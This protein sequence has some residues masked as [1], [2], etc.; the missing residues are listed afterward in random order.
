VK[1]KQLCSLLFIEGALT[2]GVGALLAGGFAEN[3]MYLTKGPSTP[4][5]I[6]KLAKERS[7]FREEEISTGLLLML[8]GLPLLIMSILSVVM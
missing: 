5:I 2:I 1:T 3:R 7:E 6:E 8:A 4:Y